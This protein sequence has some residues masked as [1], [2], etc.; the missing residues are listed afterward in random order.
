[1]SRQFFS[2]FIVR[3]INSIIMLSL[4]YTSPVDENYVRD[5]PS[6]MVRQHP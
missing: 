2:R 3:L 4:K 5:M 6:Q 1:M